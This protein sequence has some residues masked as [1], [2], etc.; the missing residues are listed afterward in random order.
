MGLAFETC[1]VLYNAEQISLIYSF[2]NLIFIGCFLKD[3]TTP[4]YNHSNYVITFLLFFSLLL[5][6]LIN[7]SIFV[8]LSVKYF[9]QLSGAARTRKL[10]ETFIIPSGQLSDSYCLLALYLSG[11]HRREPPSCEAPQQPTM[12]MSFLKKVLMHQ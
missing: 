8:V 5:A 3:Q 1:C 12:Y 11:I 2:S 9:D 7:P 6:Q 10:V 4:L